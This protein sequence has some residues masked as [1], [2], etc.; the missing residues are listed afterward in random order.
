MKGIIVIVLL[1]INQCSA[2]KYNAKEE[3]DKRVKNL[4]R[5]C[6][7][8]HENQKFSD[9]YEDVQDPTK[10]YV[11]NWASKLFMCVPAENGALSWNRFFR[12]LHNFDLKV[13]TLKN[14]L[15]TTKFISNPIWTTFPAL[16]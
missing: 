16:V 10:N 3:I 11:Q 2:V 6:D 4:K 13:L 7:K 12:E 14:S 1:I 15:R 5:I 8:Y 9:L